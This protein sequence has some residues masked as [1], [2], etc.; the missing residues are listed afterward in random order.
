LVAAGAQRVAIN[1]AQGQ[2]VGSGVGRVVGV[3]LAFAAGADDAD[4]DAAIGAQHAAEI[5]KAQ[6]RRAGGEGRRA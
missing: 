3:A 1:I 2:D 4:G 5:R 6:G